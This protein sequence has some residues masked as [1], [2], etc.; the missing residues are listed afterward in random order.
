MFKHFASRASALG[1]AAMVTL[2]T[3]A[4][5]NTLALSEQAG[6]ELMAGAGASD[7]T[8]LAAIPAS[9]RS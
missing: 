1:L 6:S 3:L 2:A 8:A 9:P 5:I 4:G 7:H